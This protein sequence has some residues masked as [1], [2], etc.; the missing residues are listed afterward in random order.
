MRSAIDFRNAIAKAQ[1]KRLPPPPAKPAGKRPHIRV[2][3]VCGET[4]EA[5]GK[6]E[7]CDE[8]DCQEEEKRWKKAVQ[9]KA[10][11]ARNPKRKTAYNPAARHERWEREKKARG[12][13]K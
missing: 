5:Q 6:R 1:A 9:A 4:F 7:W 3:R 10:N 11:R 12:V 2:C 8:P 13:V